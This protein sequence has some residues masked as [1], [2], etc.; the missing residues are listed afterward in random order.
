M[1]K[2]GKIKKRAIESDYLSN[3][4]RQAASPEVVALTT[5]IDTCEIARRNPDNLPVSHR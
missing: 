4:S 5:I 2:G 3:S 1:R